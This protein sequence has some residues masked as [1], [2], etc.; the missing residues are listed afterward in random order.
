MCR[1]ESPPAI[2][3]RNPLST[4]G[5]A[6]P[7]SNQ[8]RPPTRHPAPALS[9]VVAC[10]ERPDSLHRCIA[11]LQKTCNGIETEII[12]VTAVDGFR[13]HEFSARYPGI[14]Y[15]AMP[16]DTLVPRLWSEGI[17]ASAAE[18]VALTIS[19]CSASPGWARSMLSAISRGAV[20]AGG[21]LT[22]SPT[23]SRFDSAIFFLRYS[24]YLA[25][26]SQ[27]SAG[28]AGDNCVYTSKALEAGGWSRTAGFWEVEVN[29]LLAE[30]G[31][32]IAWVPEAEMEFGDGGS[33]TANTRR[34]FVHGRHFGASRRIDRG[35]SSTRILLASPLVPMVLFGR[36][37]RRAWPSKE[38][39]RKLI[40][41]APA[42][43]VLS[44]AWALGEA[45]G[46]IGGRSA[47]RS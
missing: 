22:L 2:Q 6:T 12:V 15:I 30:R 39:R 20:A 3:A 14:R 16:A 5:I 45:V 33:V 19:Q 8:S 26:R 34:R 10:A 21:P 44:A 24:A 13:G 29:K 31:D 37:V 38:Y 35:E 36:A 25:G 47:H 23:A 1:A 11:S 17:T 43:A 27:T 41:A 46:A 40:A 9:V 7:H 28:I 32:S 18:V 4:P 42:F